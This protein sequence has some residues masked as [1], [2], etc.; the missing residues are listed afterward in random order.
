MASVSRAQ[1]V[2]NAVLVLLF[3]L[4]LLRSNKKPVQCVNLISHARGTYSTVHV[5]VYH[6]FMGVF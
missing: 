1:I 6:G 3:K 2:P 4:Y 5:S